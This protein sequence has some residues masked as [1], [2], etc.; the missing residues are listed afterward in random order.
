MAGLC[1]ISS[2]QR[3]IMDSMAVVELSK[4]VFGWNKLESP[5]DGM[6]FKK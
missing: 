3:P 6:F 2:Q 1:W 4:L 5:E